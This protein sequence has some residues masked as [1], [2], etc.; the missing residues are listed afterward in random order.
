MLKKSILL[1]IFLTSISTYATT[2][3]K[4]EVRAVWLTTL[5][6]LDWPTVKATNSEMA[7]RQQQ[8]LC[9]IL[10]RLQRANVNTVLLQT[11]VRATTIYP[12]RYE[13]FDAC[14][15]G[16]GGSDPGYDPLEFAISECHKRGMELHAW[17]VAIPVGKWNNI[18]CKRLRE[19]YPKLIQKIGD[20]GYMNPERRETGEYI[21]NICRE[22]TERYDIDGIHLDYIRYPENWKLK[23]SRNEGRENITS[24]VRQIHR[25]VK[26]LKPWIKISCSPVGKYRSLPDYPSEGWNAYDKVCQDAQGWL[27]DGLMDQLYPMMYFRG[28]NFYPF[29]VDWAQHTYGRTI[30]TGLGIWLLSSGKEGS[31]WPLTD[32]IRELNVSRSLG[33][34]HTYF[35]SRFFTDNTKGIFSYVSDNFD[36]YPS[37]TPPM[38]WQS[39]AKP[40]APVGIKLESI[41]ERLFISWWGGKDNSG[42]PYLMYN[43]Y[44]S[45]STPVDTSDPRNLIAQRVKSPNITLT[46]EDGSHYF[47]VTS[48][49]RYGNESEGIQS[50]RKESLKVEWIHCDGREVKLPSIS[51]DLDAHHLVIKSLA[52]TT[53]TMRT[54]GKATINVRTLPDGVYTINVVD[55]HKR[56]YRIGQFIIKR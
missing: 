16:K 18:G 21:S 38:T 13:P 42:G 56:E 26:S 23:V 40:T 31:N 34:G 55:R 52:G 36:A 14:L 48:I 19:R 4:H 6:S 46:S 5:N 51:P 50:H 33:M 9:S 7:A 1:L 25:T 2:Y 43:V 54:L 53:M 22:I 3:P 45:K 11:R 49:D 15:T 17:V 27:R 37:L 8:Q 28:N 24:I 35:R 41:G 29:A 10:D 47:A 30:V 39:S 32:I 12:S 20:E 44:A